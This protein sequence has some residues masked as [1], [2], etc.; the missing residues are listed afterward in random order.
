M[1]KYASRLAKLLGSTRFI[2]VNLVFFSLWIV[3]HFSAGFD[4]TW[5]NLTVVLSIEAIFLALFILRAENVQVAHIEEMLESEQKKE[6]KE[7]QLLKE[8][9]KEVDEP[10]K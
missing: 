6:D 9:E 1:N 5:T 4:P 2:L 3:L 7:I 8:I 10:K